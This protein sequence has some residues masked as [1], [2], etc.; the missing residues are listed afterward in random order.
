L[1]SVQKTSNRFLALDFY[2][3]QADVYQSNGQ[4]R[5]AQESILDAIRIA[6]TGLKTITNERERFV[7]SRYYSKVYRSLVNLELKGNVDQALQWWEWYKGA[8][9]RDSKSRNLLLKN[10]SRDG[11][12]KFIVPSLADGPQRISFEYD[13]KG[14]KSLFLAYVIFPNEVGVWSRNEVRIQYKKLLISPQ[15]LKVVA[16]RYAD[17]CANPNS[18]MKQIATDARILYDGLIRPFLALT[19]SHSLVIEPDGV[20]NAIPFDGLVN[21]EGRHLGDDYDISI[22]PGLYYLSSTRDVINPSKRFKSLVV[23]NS[24]PGLV[25]GAVLQQVPSAALEARQ[26]A[27]ILPGSTLLLDREAT[28]DAVVRDIRIA[29]VF[30]FSGHALTTLNGLVL[31]LRPDPTAGNSDLLDAVR[32]EKAS[33]KQTRLVVLSACTTAGNEH[34][35]VEDANNLVRAFIALGVPQVIASRWSVDSASTEELM[36]LFYKH[37]LS[38]VSAEIALREAKLELRD[39]LGY[40]HPYYWSAFSLFGKPH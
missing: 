10:W 21:E 5:A 23:G 1:P 30:H 8:P 4:L 26:V 15:E 31:V 29:D 39:G 6:E 12:S 17:N 14:D 38:G 3:T 16:K 9:L 33:V 20:L 7:W 35:T 13:S 40:S 37:L 28:S 25:S 11:V 22:S 34:Q 2:L 19:A 27:Q 32:L 36:K 24:S 18:G